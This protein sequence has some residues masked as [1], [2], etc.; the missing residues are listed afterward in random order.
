M[1]LGGNR[2]AGEGQQGFSLRTSSPFPGTGGVLSLHQALRDLDRPLHGIFF[3]SQRVK[4][5]RYFLVL[6]GNSGFF[7]AESEMESGKGRRCRELAGKLRCKESRMGVSAHSDLWRV[8]S[9][10]QA[11]DSPSEDTDSIVQSPSSL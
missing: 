7:W 11:T 3:L 2:G 9:P 1:G 10:P 5:G 8:P 4:T 6:I